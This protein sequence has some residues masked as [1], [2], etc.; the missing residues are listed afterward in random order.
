MRYEVAV[1]LFEHRG[2]ENRERGF[3]LLFACCVAMACAPIKGC[4]ADNTYV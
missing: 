3:Q 4:K 2:A 1:T